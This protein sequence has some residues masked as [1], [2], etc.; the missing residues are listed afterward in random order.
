M[1]DKLPRPGGGDDDGPAG[2]PTERLLR[3]AM[4]ARTSLITAHDLRPAAPPRTR[5]R[6]LR[7]VYAVTVPLLGLAAAAFLASGVAQRVNGDVPRDAAQEGPE[8]ARPRGR[9]GRPE[10]VERIVHALLRVA[11]VAEHTQRHRAAVG[12]VFLRRRRHRTLI[13]S[14]KQLDYPLV[15]H[16]L[17]PS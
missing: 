10:P 4:N 7:P 9:Y 3:E 15:V 8:A 6:R 1:T 2:T 13:P 17:S 11:L 16:R 5:V 14:Q 12:A